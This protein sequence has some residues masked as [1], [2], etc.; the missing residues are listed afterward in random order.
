MSTMI[1]HPNS[2]QKGADTMG[3]IMD[4]ES[5]EFAE[6]MDE[7]TAFD[8]KGRVWE[9]WPGGTVFDSNTG[10]IRLTTSWNDDM[11]CNTDN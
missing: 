4:I 6:T 1:I 3:I 5:G 7:F 2:K 8:M 9:R 11:E 10:K